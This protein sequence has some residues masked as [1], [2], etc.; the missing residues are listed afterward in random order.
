MTRV[1]W[2]DPGEHLYQIGI[3]R[4]M[5][6]TGPDIPVAVPWSGLVGVTE[7]PVIVGPQPFYLDGRKVLNLMGGED[8]AATIEAF[9]SPLEFAPCAGRAHLSTGFFA[10]SQPK[11]PFHFSYRTLHGNDILGESYGYRVHIV[12][13]AT[14]QISNFDHSTIAES[15]NPT[16]HSWSITT[17]P[18]IFAGARPTAHVIFDTR[19]Q[20]ADSID[21]I[22]A[23]LYG[24]VDEGPRI[25]TPEEIVTTLVL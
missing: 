24:D 3:D 9:A 21:T 19:I 5:L 6:Y 7:A 10:A 16:T 4:G 2:D 20:T 25:P 18:V 15:S 23:I 17:R 12:Y 22:E 8:F 14:A 11:Q 13:N 1:T